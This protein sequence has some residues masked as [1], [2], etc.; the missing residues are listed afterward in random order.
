[1]AITEN[2]LQQF[3]NIVREY[4]NSLNDR[5]VK[6][7]SLNLLSTSPNNSTPAICVVTIPEKLLTTWHKMLD[8]NLDWMPSTRNIDYDLYQYKGE[9]IVSNAVVNVSKIEELTSGF[10][11]NIGDKIIEFD[12]LIP[13]ELYGAANMDSSGTSLNIDIVLDSDEEYQFEFSLASMLH[14]FEAV[15]RHTQDDQQDE[16]LP[17]I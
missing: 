1:M 6:F 10:S 2:E 11:I 9:W 5:T 3:T 8:L 15:E 16:C 17:R 14:A 7:A 4:E 13:T 12:E